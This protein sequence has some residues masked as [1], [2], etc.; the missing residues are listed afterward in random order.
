MMGEDIF[1]D[2]PFHFYYGKESKYNLTILDG[3]LPF[4]RGP[5]EVL[6]QAFLT[7]SFFFYEMRL[8]PH[9]KAWQ[10]QMGCFEIRAAQAYPYA[11]K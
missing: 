6:I 11:Y 4:F 1:T 2:L 7:W 9:I 8:G 3:F 10:S 5:T